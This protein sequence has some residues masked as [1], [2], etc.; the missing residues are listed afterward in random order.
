MKFFHTLLQEYKYVDFN[1]VNDIL[2]I[3]HLMLKITLTVSLRPSVFP[4]CRRASCVSNRFLTR[5]FAH[6]KSHLQSLLEAWATLIKF[7]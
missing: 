1:E 5:I 7:L 4:N 2:R 3:F 6:S